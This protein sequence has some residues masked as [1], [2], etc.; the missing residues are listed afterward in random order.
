MRDG[1]QATLPYLPEGLI[2]MPESGNTK[3][4]TF[5]HMDLRYAQVIGSPDAFKAAPSYR[6]GP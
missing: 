5:R 1:E 4:N 2:S 3:R 6:G